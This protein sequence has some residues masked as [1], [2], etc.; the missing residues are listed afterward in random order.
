MTGIDFRKMRNDGIK[1]NRGWR[2]NNPMNIRYV[3]ANKWKYKVKDE[4]KTDKAFEE[5]T[6]CVWG[7]RAAF[8]LLLKYYYKNKLRTPRMI[9][10]RWAPATEN[11]TDAY[12]KNVMEF[13]HKNGFPTL[14]ENATLGNPY[15]YEDQWTLLMIAMTLQESGKMP[16][17]TEDMSLMRSFIEY[18]QTEVLN[19]EK[20]IKMDADYGC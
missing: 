16:G 3:A 11:N 7:W 19:L 12:V 9:I 14:Q 18:A 5:F 13:M 1:L 10:S 17:D 20:T 15:V 6:N 8:Y 4:N 2:N